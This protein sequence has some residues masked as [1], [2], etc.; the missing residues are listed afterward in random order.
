MSRIGRLPIPIPSGVDVAVDGRAVTVKG[1][2]GSLALTVAEPISVVSEDGVIRVT[3]PNDE[4]RNRALHGLSRTLIYNMVTGVA[5]LPGR[6]VG[7]VREALDAGDPTYVTLP[8]VIE[9]LRPLSQLQT[10]EYFLST[11]VDAT[12][13]RLVGGIGEEKLVLVACGRVTA[14]IDLSKI[15]EDDIR[16]EGTKVIITLPAPEIFGTALD[17]ESGCTYVYDHS[18]PILTEP[19]TE[20][21][22]EARK[23]A[24]ES[25]RQTALE[26]GILEKAYLRAQE[27]IARLLLLAGYETVEY[28][29]LG[30]E[31]L[32]PQ[33]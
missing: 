17:D 32:L 27:E 23:L 26:N 12:K 9:Q 1:P 15:Q 20:L 13:P 21:G 19:S 30:D 29:D 8:A 24:V 28:T 25:F 5:D 11:V 16:S 18:H 3:R 7:G 31:I 4:G 6:V 2:K 14:G 33:E 22:T 10:E